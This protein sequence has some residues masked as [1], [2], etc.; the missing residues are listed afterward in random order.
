MCVLQQTKKVPIPITFSL[1]GN[2][3][4]FQNNQKMLFHFNKNFTVL[5]NCQQ[6]L[7]NNQLV[8]T[9]LASCGQQDSL[10]LSNSTVVLFKYGMPQIF[11]VPP[12][13]LPSKTIL[14]ASFMKKSMI[15]PNDVEKLKPTINCNNYLNKSSVQNA[16]NMSL[17]HAILQ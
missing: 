1:H 11:H 7:D 17:Q 8:W 3:T 5:I 15:L 10:C 4:F 14:E 9:L 6:L 12:K 2:E 13:M 16:S